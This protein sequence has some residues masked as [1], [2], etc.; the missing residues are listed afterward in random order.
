MPTPQQKHIRANYKRL[1]IDLRPDVLE[2]FKRLCGE[3]NTTGTT[4]V[5][6]FIQDY[7]AKHS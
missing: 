6:A 5:K 1:S 7:I 2:E 3:N 4:E